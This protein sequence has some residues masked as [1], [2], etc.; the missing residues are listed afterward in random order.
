MQAAPQVPAW[1][2]LSALLAPAPA[3]P[4]LRIDHL[5]VVAPAPKAAEPM[6][7]RNASA[8]PPAHE[9]APVARPAAR[10]YRSPWSTRRV[11]WD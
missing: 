3:A 9:A 1:P 8:A 11:G 5:E 7:P 2:D 10:A 4:T 6:T